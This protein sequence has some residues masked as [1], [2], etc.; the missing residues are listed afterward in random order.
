MSVEMD[1]EREPFIYI[2][3][4]CSK[5]GKRKRRLRSS[6]SSRKNKIPEKV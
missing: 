6:D 2:P 4:I 1:R 5:K 3:A